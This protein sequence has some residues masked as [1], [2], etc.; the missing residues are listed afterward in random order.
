MS[1][2]AYEKKFLGR[3]NLNEKVRSLLTEDL[4]PP[5]NE[6]AVAEEVVNF[7]FLCGTTIWLDI[8]AS[9]TAGTAPQL[10]P[11]HPS[12]ITSTK[13]QIKLEDI[14]GCRNWVMLQIGRIAELHE[15]KTQA[16]RHGQ[17]DCTEFKQT[18][19]DI[20]AEIQRG[21]TQ[22]TPEG[23]G[24]SED[25]LAGMLNTKSD[26]RILVT[27][28]FAHMASIYLH[29]VA[30][31]FEEL[32][33]LENIISETMEVLQTQVPKNILPALVCPL[34]VIGAAARRE[35]EPFFRNVFSSAPLLDPFLKHRGEI[36][37]VLEGIWRGRKATSNFAWK[38]CLALTPDSLLL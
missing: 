16:V 1:Q 27:R 15:L 4:P 37:P 10:L 13:A 22:A 23:F 8:T 12:T 9:I 3:L 19:C 28:I 7:R 11:Y 26:P 35:D 31:G 32:D 24:I 2:Q 14:M 30:L 25:G 38:D 20:G 29:M 34:F 17:F 5:E 6:P 36:L 21:L 33:I 18:T